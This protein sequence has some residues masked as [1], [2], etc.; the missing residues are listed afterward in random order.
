M[1]IYLVWGFLG[2]GKTTLINH[3]LSISSFKGKRIVIL[4]NESGRE[5]VDG[6][7]LRSLQ[8]TVVDL[9]GGC[10]CCTL[11]MK[12][13]EILHELEKQYQ[14]NVVLIESSGL[15]SLE[16]M[17]RIP[18]LFLSGVLTVLDVLQY[19]FL[20]K[21]NPLHYKRQFY[22]SSVVF[23]TKTAM[24]E[25]IKVDAI[26]QDL[27]SY[28]PSL[29]I[30]S[31]YRE[32]S[33]K[34]WQQIWEI[35]K[36][37]RHLF[38]PVLRNNKAPMF[39]TETFYL[40]S[41][42]DTIF[43]TDDFSMLNKLFG[44]TIV[45]AKGLI[46][47]AD[48]NWRKFDFV[49]GRMDSIAVY[50]YQSQGNGF[51]TIWWDSSTDI[52]PNLWLPY[53]LNAIEINCSVHNLKF[54]DKV[55][56]RFLGFKE[57]S[58]DEGL[59][60]IIQKLKKEALD[61][62]LPRIGIRFLTGKKIDN[63]HLHIGGK[64]FTPAKVITQI[65]QDAEFYVMVLV[66]TGYEFDEWMNQK[67]TSGDIIEGFV[68][69]GIGSTLTDAV[70]RYAQSEIEVYLK[71]WSIK[72]SNTYSP[73]YCDWDVAEQNIFFSLL[74]D[75]FCGVNLTESSLMLPIKSVSTFMGAGL[76]I[77]KKA[78][79]CAICSKKDCYKRNK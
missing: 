7:V 55:L 32:L 57:E 75:L 12:L 8:C 63:E 46:K 69:D 19:D 9:K 66:S 16:E 43:F 14:P 79:G 39:D 28:Q 27:L 37:R 54:D 33:D 23:L 78:Y 2:S 76:E 15:A 68:A 77:E 73:G 1:E 50:D 72:V 49:N 48:N 17:K 24:C 44:D 22:F 67:R 71:R 47:M 35:V 13:V 64:T 4:E 10:M 61:L 53:F 5:S 6:E 11:R 58:L 25:K 60:T 3:L 29:Y 59:T 40:T 38:L 65:L 26:T 45:R 70:V 42:V 74:P 36:E 52:N 31:D 56:Y 18:G 34:G 20:M 41:P 21:L 51:L 30:V 62:C